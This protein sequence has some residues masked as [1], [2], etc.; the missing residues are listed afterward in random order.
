MRS[1]PTSVSLGLRHT[2]ARLAVIRGLPRGDRGGTVAGSMEK[3]GVPAFPTPTHRVVPVFYWPHTSDTT[4]AATSA[5]RWQAAVPVTQLHCRLWAQPVSST[6]AAGTERGRPHGARTARGWSGR[7]ADTSCALSA[8][9]PHSAALF[10]ASHRLPPQIFSATQQAPR[11][12]RVRP[13]QQKI[14]RAVP[15]PQRSPRFCQVS[16]RRE[17]RPTQASQA[18]MTSSA[19]DPAGLPAAAAHPARCPL[20][21]P[22]VE[23]QVCVSAGG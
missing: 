16:R 13:S 4:L 2:G 9:V 12:G 14:G 20:A 18:V 19:P 15:P 23:C 11:R 8:L 7:S 3:R 17:I 5:A 22:L 1:P 10:L 21:Q 6:Q